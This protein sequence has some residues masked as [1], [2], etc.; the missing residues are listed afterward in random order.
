VLD[1][2][3][4]LAALGHALTSQNRFESVRRVHVF[5]THAHMDHWEGLK[6]A[7]WFWYRD[8]GL[9]VRITAPQQA[10][11]AIRSGYDHPSYVPLE[12]LSQGTLE[13]LEFRIV[14][15]GDRRGVG[16]WRVRTGPLNHYSGAGDHIHELETVGYR[17]TLRNGPT[18]AYLCDHEPTEATTKLERKLIGGAHLALYDAHFPNLSDHKFGHG[19]QEH[20]A[21]MAREHAKTLILAAHHGPALSDSE[22]RGAMRRH[23]RGLGNYHVA[24]EG[25]TYLWNPRR[26]AF[27]LRLRAAP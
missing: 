22:I 19:S 26:G 8:N 17:L 11:D 5:I 15:A 10:L 3:R 13:R 6:D 20:A 12:L 23:G 27:V 25:Q 21:R 1:A 16:R 4:G 2:G 9:Q 7:D 18:I 14:S 24:V